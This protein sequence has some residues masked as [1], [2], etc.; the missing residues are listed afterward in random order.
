MLDFFNNYFL[1]ST[2]WQT[3]GISYFLGA[4][5]SSDFSSSL[6][7][8]VFLKILEWG[9]ALRA[10]IAK[11]YAAPIWIP[12]GV[13]IGVLVLWG[14]NLWPAICLSSFLHFSIINYEQYPETFQFAGF[15]QLERHSKLWPALIS[16]INAH[17][18]CLSRSSQGCRSF[19]ACR[20]PFHPLVHSNRY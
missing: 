3:Q 11:F 19:C 5:I 14:M 12:S 13:A 16:S 20:S 15:M 7:L 17:L 10:D 2:L 9:L 1:T 18:H 6:L 4:S 8:T